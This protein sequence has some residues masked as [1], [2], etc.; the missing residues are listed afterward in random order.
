M[1]PAGEAGEANVTKRRDEGLF[2]HAHLHSQVEL[3]IK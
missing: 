1:A 3:G 2:H